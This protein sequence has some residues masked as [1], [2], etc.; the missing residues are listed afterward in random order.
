MQALDKGFGK[1]HRDGICLL[2]ISSVFPELSVGLSCVLSG[3]GDSYFKATEAVPW[4]L[5]GCQFC[6][7]YCNSWEDL[8]QQ[9]LKEVQ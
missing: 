9:C 5:W 4:Y 6:G 8:W 3:K 7:V 1:P 2:L